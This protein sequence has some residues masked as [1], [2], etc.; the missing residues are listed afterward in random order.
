MTRLVYLAQVLRELAD[1]AEAG[2]LAGISVIGLRRDRRP[3][4]IVHMPST[5]RD[6]AGM[7]GGLAVN[8]VIVAE[9]T[10]MTAE[11]AAELMRNTLTAMIEEEGHARADR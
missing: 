6:A 3:V 9:S 1:D 8:L 7:F 5:P 10:G 4:A 11:E 2:R